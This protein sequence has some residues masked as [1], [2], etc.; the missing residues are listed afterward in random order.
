MANII[1]NDA[2]SRI[3]GQT[4][5][6]TSGVYRVLLVRSTSAYSPDK[7]DGHLDEFF[8]GGGVEVSVTS[9]SRKTLP[10]CVIDF[11]S[12]PVYHFEF[13][14]GSVSFGSLEAGQTAIAMIVYEQVGGSDSTPATDQM[15][16][17]LDTDEDGLMPLV[18]NG[19]TVTIGAR[20]DGL[21]SFVPLN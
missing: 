2:I 9:Y 16:L 17:Y 6:W 18:L 4:M 1:F 21:F 11:A 12:S 15:I 5:D 3:V 8:S 20:T 19:G 10:D 14:C 13:E 7:G